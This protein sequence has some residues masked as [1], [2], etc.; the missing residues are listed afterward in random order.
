MALVWSLLCLAGAAAMGQQVRAVNSDPLA[1]E[2][3]L[4]GGNEGPLGPIR[5]AGA[6]N[7][8]FSG[9]VVLISDQPIA[10]ASAKMGDLA[11]AG[12]KGTIPATAVQIRYAFNPN[13]LECW[14]SFDPL[15]PV[16]P[17]TA[18][19]LVKSAFG[20]NWPATSPAMGH[21]LLPVWVTVHV[22]ADAAPGDYKGS[23]QVTAGG[24]TLDVP[25]EL[26][27]SAW[28]LP[29][30]RAFKTFVELIESPESV[31]L[32]YGVPLWSDEH[33]KLIAKSLEL[34]GQVGN[35][36]AYIPLICRTNMGNEQTMVRWIRKGDKYEYDFAPMDKYLDL[37]EKHC[38]RPRF[39]CLYVWDAFLPSTG[40]PQATPPDVARE[41][42][43]LKGKGPP[44]SVLDADGRTV[45]TE[46]LAQYG[47][48]EALAQWRPLLEAIRDRLR[49]RSL[50]SA[51]C[52]GIV[53]DAE[54]S[55]E[56]V[57]LFKEMLPGVPWMRRGH[58]RIKSVSGVALSLQE[59]PSNNTWAYDLKPS[60]R[61]YGWRE[62]DKSY[63]GLAVHFP[64]GG[65]DNSSR[66]MFRLM[67]EANIAG[68]QAGFGGWG[69]DFW[70]ALKDKRGNKVGRLS[71]RYPESQWR[72]LDIMTA[73]LAPGPDGAIATVRF[74]MMREGIQECEA[75]ISIEQAL[76]DP[77]LRAM[78]GDDLAGR[79]QAV[80]DER[81][82]AMR[83][84]MKDDKGRAM[85]GY[86]GTSWTT[87]RLEYPDFIKSP[88]Q[89]RS[90]KLFDAAAEVAAK[91]GAK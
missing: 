59:S 8:A 1:Q 80:L 6:R 49:K 51:L 28:R 84:L 11:L 18:Q 41:R 27:V 67:G 56:V 70:P 5:L 91:I 21:A 7:G 3:D 22:P 9:K 62:G 25:V 75:R 90:S 2:F 52:Y 54:P 47:S 89:E 4:G 37:V 24:K 71:A 63:P 43:T 16:P 17:Q 32:E 42:E 23:L 45:T 30:P 85:F 88:W 69:A 68:M 13:T 29:E 87:V 34:M 10:G 78:L 19:V 76:T 14:H 20:R 73:L 50:D 15:S 74:E 46:T 57:A 12:G 36:T 72:N 60:E 39:V 33:F 86:G 40:I 77:K 26:R 83:E 64:R 58:M 35:R 61:R 55:K 44:V 38:G 66:C 82:A 31:A 65:R 79:C 48:P 81:I 53:T